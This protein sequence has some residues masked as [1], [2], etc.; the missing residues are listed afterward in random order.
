MSI[1]FLVWGG[2]GVLGFGGGGGKCRFYFYGRE[3]FSEI[4]LS[5]RHSVQKSGLDVQDVPWI[6][7]PIIPGTAPRHTDHQIPS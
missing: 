6:R 4:R 7:P 1:K 2:G 3:D 5:H